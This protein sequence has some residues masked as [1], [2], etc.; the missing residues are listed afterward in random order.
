[1]R[2]FL[3]PTLSTA[4]P[5]TAAERPH[6]AAVRWVRTGFYVLLLVS[7][8]GS[9]AAHPETGRMGGFVSG[10]KHPLTGLDH[11]VAMV[12]VGLWGAFLG[13]P[14]MWLLPV[15]FPLV[16]AVGGA[17][18]IMGIPLPGTEMGIATSGIVLGIMVAARAR[19]PLWIAAALTGT[20]AIFHGY[21]HG[22]ELP[23]SA[24]PITYA[25]GFVIA[26]GLL[27]LSGV[28]FGLLTRWR[29][30]RLLVQAAGVA[31]AVVGLG[32]LFRIF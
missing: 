29:W 24:N 32:F 8:A 17:A 15:T 25:V 31:I 16:M 19:P 13:P 23:R 26:T 4:R 1:M 30:G 14:A 7:T 12:A 28:A 11:I 3:L 18:G 9:A 21:A 20:F 10:F 5:S 6:R 22:V 2:S 27:H